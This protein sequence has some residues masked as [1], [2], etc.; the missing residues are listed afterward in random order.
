MYGYRLGYNLF[1]GARF[2][3][4]QLLKLFA[5][6]FTTASSYLDWYLNGESGTYLITGDDRPAQPTPVLDFTAGGTIERTMAQLSGTVTVE[7]VTTG[8]I[9]ATISIA[10]SV[11]KYVI[12]PP[13]G[14]VKDIHI[15]QDGVTIARLLCEEHGT[16][17]DCD[18]TWNV[19]L[20][21]LGNYNF[22]IVGAT[23][24]DVRTHESSIYCDANAVGY[25]ESDGTGLIPLDGWVPALTSS[26]D[27]NGDALTYTGKAAQALEVVKQNALFGDGTMYIEFANLPTYTTA[28]VIEDGEEVAIT[29]TSNQ[30]TPTSGKY[31]TAVILKDGSDNEVENIPLQAYDSGDSPT[32]IVY[33][34]IYDNN[35]TA[36]AV[37]FTVPDNLSD[38]D[39]LSYNTENG[40]QLIGGI[41]GYK[42]PLD[43][44]GNPLYFDVDIFKIETGAGT[45]D[46]SWNAPS[47]SFFWLFSDG[48]VSTANQPTRTVDAGSHYLV[49]KTGWEGNY[50][51]RGNTTGSNYIGN[52]S[53]FPPLTY[54][55]GFL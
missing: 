13:A 3:L 37:N 27:I 5:K 49:T 14:I 6:W 11:D 7:A 30:W 28:Y 2:Q 19:L 53:D 47:G 12:T 31:Y 26:T 33:D 45:F 16:K 8:N 42:I 15:K 41:L 39:G 1:N 34:G 51:L 25:S 20:D 52:L 36:T 32:S 17:A 21:K 4:G 48:D 38:R 35:A 44:N 29:I 46:F 9:A 50:E 22:T 43:I 10:Y 24:P 23:Y 54:F 40:Y 18:S 55:A